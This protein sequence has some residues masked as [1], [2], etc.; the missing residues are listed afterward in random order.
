MK[1]GVRLERMAYQT[2][3]T[4][5]I[6]YLLGIPMPHQAEG[7]V[8]YEALVDP[9]LHLTMRKKAEKE[10]DRWRALY[11]GIAVEYDLNPRPELGDL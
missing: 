4:P 7:A 6:C 9:D 10:R 1:E 8:L 3:V 5:T 11:R 2:Q